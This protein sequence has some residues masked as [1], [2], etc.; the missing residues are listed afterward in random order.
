MISSLSGHGEA[1]RSAGADL[2]SMRL[3]WQDE[4]GETSPGWVL[5]G[6]TTIILAIGLFLEWINDMHMN[7]YGLFAR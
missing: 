4:F 5:A 3:P 2:R 7:G 1:A 6:I